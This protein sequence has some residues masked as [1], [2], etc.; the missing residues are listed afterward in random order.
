MMRTANPALNDNTFTGLGR[1]AA[2]GRP[3]TIQGTV[4]KTA[5]LLLFLLLS[6][7]WTW[8]LSSTQGPQAVSPWLLGGA[9]GGLVAA[10]YGVQENV[11]SG[12]G[13][14]LCPARGPG[15]RGHLVP[16]RGAVP[17]HRDSGRGPHLRH[18][19]R[20]P[21]SLQAASP[22]RSRPG[23]SRKAGTRGSRVSRP[24][25]T[26]QAIIK[27]RSR[28]RRRTSSA[29]ASL[30]TI[31]RTPRTGTPAPLWEATIS[32]SSGRMQAGRSTPSNSI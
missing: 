14:G 6:A 28:E 30:S 29:T 26:R 17:R 1:T 13:A 8:R 18:A 22:R 11:V 3:M 7:A 25:I 5:F 2:A 10:G 27:S 12:P 9:V 21:H 15:A 16:F 24:S 32:T 23:R 31:C 4:N 19:L 20:P